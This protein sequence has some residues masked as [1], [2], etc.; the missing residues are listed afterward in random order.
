M[1]VVVIVFGCVAILKDSY[2]VHSKLGI[3]PDTDDQLMSLINYSGTSKE[4]F[5]KYTVK[6]DQFLDSKHYKSYF[7]LA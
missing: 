2:D 5:E 6:I 7:L 3:I 4:E 1:V